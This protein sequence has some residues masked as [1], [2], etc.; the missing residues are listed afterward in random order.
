MRTIRDQKT[1]FDSLLTY[2]QKLLLRFNDR[3]VIDSD[4]E[5]MASL[6]ESEDDILAEVKRTSKVK[7][8]DRLDHRR[9]AKKCAF[10]KKFDRGLMRGV[11]KYR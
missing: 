11:G 4:S 9:L 2:K 3:H 10:V 6:N 1:L 5:L 8:Y 7:L